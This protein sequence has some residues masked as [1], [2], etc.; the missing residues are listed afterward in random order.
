MVD[1]RDLDGTVLQ[2]GDT[3]VITKNCLYTSKLDR[4]VILS[5]DEYEIVVGTE[6]SGN[7]SIQD[8][9]QV[10]YLYT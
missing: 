10:L 4:G 1:F 9:R 7:V 2:V 3:V 5:I 8:E 6:G